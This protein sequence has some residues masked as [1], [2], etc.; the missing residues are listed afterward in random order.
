MS[1]PPIGNPWSEMC[2]SLATK[3]RACLPRPKKV[4]P[5]Q[6]ERRAYDAQ[7]AARKRSGQKLRR[8]RERAEVAYFGQARRA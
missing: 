2:D 4:G 5:T 8:D 7:V 1:A 3:R 6:A